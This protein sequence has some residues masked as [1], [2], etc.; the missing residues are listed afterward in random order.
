MHRRSYR[1][2][3]PG[4]GQLK[5]G[6]RGQGAGARSPQGSGPGS[7]RN[8]LVGISYSVQCESF[9]NCQHALTHIVEQ[10]MRYASPGTALRLPLLRRMFF[11]YIYLVSLTSFN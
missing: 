8:E 4:Q 3:V 7:M 1:L 2:A 6:G 9:R 11:T 10:A 5:L